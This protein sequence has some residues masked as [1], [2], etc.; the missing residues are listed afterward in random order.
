MKRII[1][2]AG[3]VIVLLIN[4]RPALASYPTDPSADIAWSG[5]T[6]TVADIQAAFNNA[7]TQEN[8]QLGKSIPLLMLPS[9]ATWNAMSDGEK[10][11]W[12]S[13]RERIDRGVLAM[14]STEANVTSVAQYYAAYL[15]SHNTFSHNADGRS[16]WQRLY[17]NSAINACHDSLGVAENL[18]VFVT[19]G[20]SIPLPIERSIYMFMY[21]DA[22]S[23]WGHRHAILWYPY[24]DNSG[25]SDKEGFLGIG[26]A[27]GGPY[28]GPFSQPWNYA[29]IIVMNFFDPCASWNYGSTA[30]KTFLPLVIR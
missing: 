8:A 23:A 6:S 16:P 25:P 30:F 2:V 10:A 14:H 3:I 19:S 1:I 9:Q 28:Q 20:N 24:N 17:T 22:G 27:H 11:F 5:G 21:V 13:N 15:L 29:E 18:A 12:L 26:R 7:R 4:L